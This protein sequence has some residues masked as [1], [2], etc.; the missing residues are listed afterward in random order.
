MTNRTAEEAKQNYIAVMGRPLGAL[1]HGLWQEVVWLSYQWRE[2]EE[3]FGRGKS[4]V[5]LMN[6][7]APAFFRMVQ[8]TLWEQTL[9]HV[10]RLT[11]PPKSFGRKN[12]SIQC[13][14]PSMTDSS[15]RQ[16]IEALTRRALCGSE[17]CRDWRNRRIAH[18][19]LVLS[20]GEHAEPLASATRVKVNAALRAIGDVLNAVEQHYLQATTLF[21]PLYTGGAVALLH[22]ID[23]GLRVKLERRQRRKRS[24]SNADDLPHHDL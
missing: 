17:F 13:L 22:V 20:L 10:A 18:R 9:L 15:T 1:F 24:E 5:D 14:A 19:D 21:E 7:V 11:D 2:Y 16:E 8:D 23:D 12:L 6:Q 3:L 4:R